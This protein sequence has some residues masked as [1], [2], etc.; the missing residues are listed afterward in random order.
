MSIDL[1]TLHTQTAFSPN[2]VTEAAIST[3]PA[4]HSSSCATS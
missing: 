4:T 1:N 3:G 2:N